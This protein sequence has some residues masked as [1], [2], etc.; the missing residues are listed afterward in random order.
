MPSSFH[1]KGGVL[2]AHSAD[3]PQRPRGM[4]FRCRDGHT[5]RATVSHMGSRTAS[6]SNLAQMQSADMARYAPSTGATL[7]ADRCASV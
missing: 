4:T 7:V 2:V 1:D 3:G 5:H 6:A